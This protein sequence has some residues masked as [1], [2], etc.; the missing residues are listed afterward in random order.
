MDQL[1]I[2]V[3]ITIYYRKF[4]LIYG[5]SDITLGVKLVVG[6]PLWTILIQT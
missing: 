4:A 6:F 1:W 2:S 5:Y 3:L